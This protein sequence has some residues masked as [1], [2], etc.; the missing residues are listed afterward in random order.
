MQKAPP[1]KRHF[2]SKQTTRHLQAADDAVGSLKKDSSVQEYDVLQQAVDTNGSNDDGNA[3]DRGSR[4][5]GALFRVKDGFAA[6]V[7][8]PAP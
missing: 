5:Q 6:V 2:I 8:A 3:G 4:G 7:E 1:V